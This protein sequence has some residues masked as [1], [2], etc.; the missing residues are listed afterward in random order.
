MYI[1]LHFIHVGYIYIC[2]YTFLRIPM[3]HTHTSFR[4]PS[5][6]LQV[7]LKLKYSI[8][9]QGG[10]FAHVCDFKGVCGMR[11]GLGQ[12]AGDA[13][14]LRLQPARVTGHGLNLLSL[15]RSLESLD[16]NIQQL[17]SFHYMCDD[18]KT[19]QCESWWVFAF[20]TS[21]SF[22]LR[23]S[24]LVRKW[25]Q[26]SLETRPLPCFCF[27]SFQL[28]SKSRACCEIETLAA[29]HVQ[30]PFFFPKGVGQVEQE[31]NELD[32]VVSFIDEVADCF[33]KL[34]CRFL[35]TLMK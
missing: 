23:K 3:P 30:I 27:F 6:W 10:C 35:D 4:P 32:S 24:F 28:S 5:L 8:A 14:R 20:A 21:W 25:S 22:P 31:M 34:R 33:R 19:P 12:E 26:L 17:D 29:R 15:A 1:L 16:S 9:M 13:L 11:F 2:H 7:S 18:A